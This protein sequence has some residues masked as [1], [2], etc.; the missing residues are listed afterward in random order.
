MTEPHGSTVSCLLTP[1]LIVQ[2]LHNTFVTSESES[3]SMSSPDT[4]LIGCQVSDCLI[5]CWQFPLSALY[6]LE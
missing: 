5:V 2:K 6:G 3:E 4:M 1:L